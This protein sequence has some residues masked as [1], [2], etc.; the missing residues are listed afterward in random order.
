MKVGDK[1]STID[2]IRQIHN[3]I[4]EFNRM[5]KDY[6]V[7][8]EELTKQHIRLTELI[9]ELNAYSYEK[10]KTFFTY[11]HL[12]ENRKGYCLGADLQEKR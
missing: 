6:D 8:S 12:V 10:C 2:L 4:R 1:M 11:Y 3:E 9:D 7:S 5:M